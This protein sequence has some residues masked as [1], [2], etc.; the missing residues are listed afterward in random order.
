MNSTELEQA[1]NESEMVLCRSGYTT[2]M[3]LAQLRKKAFF[4]PTPGQ[5]EQEYLAKK[6]KKEGLVPYANQNDFRME[7]I[8]EIQD[9]KGL[10]RLDSKIDW[11]NLFAVFEK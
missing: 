2:I 6:L 10:P 5:Y 1:F 7:N 3:D 4:I 8:Q 9:Y 11:T